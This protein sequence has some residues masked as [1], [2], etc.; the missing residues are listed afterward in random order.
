MEINDYAI[1]IRSKGRYKTINQKTLEVVNRSNIPHQNVYIFCPLHEIPLYEQEIGLTYNIK[2]GGSEGTNACNLKIMDFFH[3]HYKD[4]Y[5]IQMDDDIDWI[6]EKTDSVPS[7]SEKREKKNNKLIP[8]SFK[9]KN[10]LELIQEGYRDMKM[11]DLNVW[12]LYPVCNSYFMK[13]LTTT[14]GLKFLIGRVFGFINDSDTV[15]LCRTVDNYRDDYERSILFYEKDGG[16]IRYNHLT[17]LADTYIG[18]G[19]LNEIR[20]LEGMTNSVNYMKQKYPKYVRDKKC[21]SKYPEIRLVQKPPL[22][23]VV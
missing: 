22:T 12:G 2:D 21:K 4:K 10:L 6:L 15:S 18:K 13:N 11:K 16:V 5:I 19:G 1:V 17:C 9:H 8:K 3:S 23:V 7:S 14:Y 20:N